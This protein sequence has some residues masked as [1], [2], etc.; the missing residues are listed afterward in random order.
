MWKCIQLREQMGPA[1]SWY[2]S[3][4]VALEVVWHEIALPGMLRKYGQILSF[5]PEFSS[6]LPWL[7]RLKSAYILNWA[8]PTWRR[9]SLIDWIVSNWGSRHPLRQYFVKQRATLKIIN[10]IRGI[11]ALLARRL[12]FLFFCIFVIVYCCFIVSVLCFCFVFPLNQ[13]AH[14]Q[15]LTWPFET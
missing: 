2:L 10:I 11:I 13:K 3:W 5:F 12:V 1:V 8:Y 9:Y 7:K 4:Q 6:L 14:E 15:F